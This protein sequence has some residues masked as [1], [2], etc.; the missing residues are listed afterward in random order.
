MAETFFGMLLA[1]L[2]NSFW[3]QYF[4][5]INLL[6]ILIPL[7]LIIFNQND[8]VIGFLLHNIYCLFFDLTKWIKQSSNQQLTSAIF[9]LL[10]ISIV[11]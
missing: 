4:I 10:I 9:Y 3:L 7:I 1:S 6:F 8:Y 2:L 11:I 5:K